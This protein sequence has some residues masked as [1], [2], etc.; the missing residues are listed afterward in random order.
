MTAEAV[1]ERLTERFANG[2]FESRLDRAGLLVHNF[3]SLDKTTTR[4]IWETCGQHEWCKDVNDRVSASIVSAALPYHFTDDQGGVILSPSRVH[5]LCSYPGDGG[6]IHLKC[7]P[8]GFSSTC[9]PGC[10][11]KQGRSWWC[12]NDGS[13]RPGMDH[14]RCPWRPENLDQMLRQQADDI[15]TGRRQKETSCGQPSGC[16]YNEVVLSPFTPDA[17][18]A[19]FYPVGADRDAEDKA[20]RVHEEV[21]NAIIETQSP[22]LLA[23]DLKEGRFWT[24]CRYRLHLQRVDVTRCRDQ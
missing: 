9:T 2:R 20:W 8:P 12:K 22:P 16:S 13:W 5:V 19:V 11:D 18:E 7:H 24:V 10:F 17:I 14:H 21:S 6:T 23:F 15:T 1:A 4:K 3:D